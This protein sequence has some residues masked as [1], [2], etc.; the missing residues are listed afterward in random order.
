MPQQQ[1]Y[2]RLIADPN[3]LLMIAFPTVLALPVPA[4]SVTEHIL[5][6]AGGAR[7]LR[8]HQRLVNHAGRC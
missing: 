6:A 1:S 2:S 3:H 7:C 5:Q 4:E 8:Y